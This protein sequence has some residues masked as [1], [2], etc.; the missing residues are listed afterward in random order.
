[1][2]TSDAEKIEIVG[3]ASHKIRVH[4]KVGLGGGSIVAYIYVYIYTFP[5]NPIFQSERGA[6]FKTPLSF[7]SVG[8]LRSGFP[9][10]G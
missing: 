2:P 1:M 4:K 10:H 5:P 9:I 7:H 3:L 6:G 8:W